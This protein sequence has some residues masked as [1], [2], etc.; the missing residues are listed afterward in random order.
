M[1]TDIQK[2]IRT[3][4]YYLRDKWNKEHTLSPRFINAGNCD[5][6]AQELLDHFP[7]GEMMWGDECCELFP[8][9]V[10][11]QGHCFVKLDGRYYD[12]E[13]PSG[14][15]LPHLLPFYKRSLK[16]EFCL[17]EDFTDP[18]CQNCKTKVKKLDI[19]SDIC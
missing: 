9:G 10:C 13:C 7:E 1:K 19:K 5:T 14:V 17:I 4:I 18:M 8:K 11:P 2:K 16:K 3:R 12:S 15:I 6:F